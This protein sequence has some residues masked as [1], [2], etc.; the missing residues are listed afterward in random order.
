MV[1]GERGEKMSKNGEKFYDDFIDD[2]WKKPGSTLAMHIKPINEETS[3]RSNCS[4][5]ADIYDDYKE[6]IEKST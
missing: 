3:R 2:F 6:L 5:L 4:A 1:K